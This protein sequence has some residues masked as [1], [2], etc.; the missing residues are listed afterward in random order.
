MRSSTGYADVTFSSDRPWPL[1]TEVYF[2]MGEYRHDVAMITVPV[3]TPD[4]GRYVSGRPLS[5]AWGNS[6]QRSDNWYGY[7]NH[8]EP[9]YSEL[10]DEPRLQVYCIGATR[11][12]RGENSKQWKSRTIPQV[13]TDI[14]SKKRFRVESDP[15]TTV[16]PTLTQHGE[17]DWK[18]MVGLAQ[19]IGYTLTS[20]GT[21]LQLRKRSTSMKNDG[22]AI[23]VLSPS[24][25]TLNELKTSY[26]ATSPQGGDL[27]MREVWGV[28]M[29]R[30]Q[31]IYKKQSP[32]SPKFGTA[33]A[34]PVH[35]RIVTGHVASSLAEAS[36]KL[37]GLAEANRLYISGAATAP[38]NV[39]VRAGALVFVKDVSLADW[40][41]WFV[42][43][44]EHT[45]QG[46]DHTMEIDLG[47]DSV[48]SDRVTDPPT[49]TSRAPSPA[50][51]IGGVWSA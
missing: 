44:V 32:P 5:I 14:A 38:G 28:D 15:H 21:T 42:K 40:G 37:E 31:P 18:F 12:F 48:G 39:R 6:V 4:A 9:L 23:P 24:L 30:N 35:N 16:W 29:R 34:E 33:S 43:G 7:I 26:G 46:H 49:V 10:G 3:D 27:A 1:V 36:A 17:S 47:R 41:F 8:V 51:L 2:S 45:I 19:R 25:F 50:R 20:V 13:I 11:V 22:L